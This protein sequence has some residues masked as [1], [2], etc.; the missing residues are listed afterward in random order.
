MW[1]DGKFQFC[2]PLDF[3]EVV[4]NLLKNDREF[5]VQNAHVFGYTAFGELFIW[6]ERVRRLQVRLAELTAVA[7]ATSPSPL[8]PERSIATSL[9]VLE[10][11]STDL[12]ED[13]EDAPLLFSKAR[14][15]LGSLAIGE[16]YGFFP[17]LALG[18]SA[19]LKNLKKVRALEHFA[20]LSSLGPVKLL[21]YSTGQ[22]RF[23]RTLG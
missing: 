23:V 5:D 3:Q 2:N 10:D 15:S 16:C 20:L 7:D 12:R 4:S 21:D 18:G 11:A 6:H 8:P 22:R 13:S 1:L 17:A 9:I 19:L 14:R